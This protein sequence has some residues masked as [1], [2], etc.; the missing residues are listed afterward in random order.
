MNI[1]VVC[2]ALLSAL[3]FIMYPFFMGHAHNT[4][5]A[6]Q[7]PCYDITTTA[8]CGEMVPPKSTGNYEESFSNQ[9]LQ[10]NYKIQMAVSHLEQRQSSCLANPNE[11]NILD[12]HTAINE[13]QRSEQEK[14]I[15]QTEINIRQ[16]NQEILNDRAF[17]Q[18]YIAKK[19]AN[20]PVTEEEKIRIT[21]LLIQ[22]RLLG[23][24]GDVCTHGG[25]MCFYFATRF[26]VP[27]EL[28]QKMRL[29]AAQYIQQNQEPECSFDG[30]RYYPLDS[31]ECEQALLSR[32]NIIPAPLLLAQIAQ[33]S[34]Y[35]NSRWAKEYKN[36]MG[37]Q[38][39]FN[40]P[41][42]MACYKNC[43]C[44]GVDNSICALKFESIDGA[45][46][47]YYQRF[48]AG[49]AKVYANFRNKRQ[50]MK[51]IGEG[52]DDTQSQCQNARE[53]TPFLKGY[54]MDTEYIPH[55]CDG[56]NQVICQKLALCPKYQ[57]Q[58]ALTSN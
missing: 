15:C 38:A 18:A 29:S 58:M 11:A 31:T 33:E 37:L 32:V 24:K 2:K 8:Q 45:I 27:E 14:F 53:L 5:K 40:N 43:R 19:K 26:D 20:T 57:M 6:H 3:F 34:G 48:N 39:P 21:T 36:Y 9:N 12:L 13:S 47:E 52:L 49:S 46:F 55:I 41:S 7:H 25:N 54:A 22:Y 4:G 28:F 42:T 1:K 35:G 16:K 56:L 44:A 30:G 10:K 17:I 23:N 51:G 50:S